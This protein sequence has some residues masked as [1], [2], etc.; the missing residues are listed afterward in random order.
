M[1]DRGMSGIEKAKYLLF[2]KSG[3]SAPYVW[4]DREVRFD[5][6]ISALDCRTGET[7]IDSMVKMCFS[8]S[9]GS[10]HSLTT[11][12]SPGLPLLQSQIEDTKGNNGEQGQLTMTNLRLMWVSDKSHRTNLTLGYNCIVSINIREASSRLRGIYASLPC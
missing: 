4:Q 6:P 11:T 10:H 5:S 2:G 3:Q 12:A 8:P 9:A 7:V 1:P